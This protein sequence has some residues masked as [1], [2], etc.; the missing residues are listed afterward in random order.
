MQLPSLMINL[1]RDPDIVKVDC[2]SLRL[3]P[4][5]LLL[6]HVLSPH[7]HLFFVLPCR[8]YIFLRPILPSLVYYTLVND[9]EFLFMWLSLS[10]SYISSFSS[11]VFASC[12]S[13]CTDGGIGTAAMP[14]QGEKV[15]CHTNAL[16]E[17][18]GT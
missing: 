1:E 10:S 6:T 16:Y 15:G 18:E 3:H 11:S 12:S 9:P 14:L 5:L 7:K 2:S 17:G 8:T 13:S 4:F